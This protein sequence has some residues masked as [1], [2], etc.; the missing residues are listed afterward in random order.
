VKL[1]LHG[2]SGVPAESIKKAIQLGICKVNVATEIK[3]TFMK[4]LKQSLNETD[5][6]DLRKVFPNA[7]YAVN[8]LIQ[9]KLKLMH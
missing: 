5:E 9:T 2:G 4:N 1:V 3:D 6:I 8:K 7:I